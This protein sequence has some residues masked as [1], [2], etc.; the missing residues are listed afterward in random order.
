MTRTY[1]KTVSAFANFGDGEIIFGINDEG[2]V[3]GAI[4]RYHLF[5]YQKKELIFQMRYTKK[6]M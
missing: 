5:N 1:L 6:Y 3:I 2:K 4:S